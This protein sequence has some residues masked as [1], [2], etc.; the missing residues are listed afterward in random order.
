LALQWFTIYSIK[1]AMEAQRYL[2]N[3]FM[4]P[5]LGSGAQVA[6]ILPSNQHMQSVANQ[7]V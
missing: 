3:K 1:K 5:E 4:G 7:M 2:E 6:L